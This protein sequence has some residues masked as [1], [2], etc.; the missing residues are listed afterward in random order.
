MPEL[1]NAYWPYLLIAFVIGL[2]VAWLAFS[3]SR[4]TKITRDTDAKTDVLD[5]GAA[6]AQRN[7][8][9]INAAPAAPNLSSAANSQ[10]VAHASAQ[11]DAEA[12]PQI[13]PSKP[14]V[15]TPAAES[16]T[17]DASQDDLTR[18]KGLGPK[19]AKML[20]EQGIDR[21][22]QIAAWSDEDVARID[23]SLG[24]FQG[25]IERDSWVEQAKML[26]SG[27]ASAFNEKFGNH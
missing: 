9:L 13:A 27:D 16:A 2:A 21:F 22:E 26:A 1:L 7:E 18:I 14:S 24:R 23:A 25:R 10:D 4:K 5:E 12:G 19:I 20:H 11:A 8:A 17:R 15:P 3:A 6:P